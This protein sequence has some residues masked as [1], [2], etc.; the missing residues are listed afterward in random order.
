[1]SGAVTGTVTSGLDV[2]VLGS[3]AVGPAANLFLTQS[4]VQ[5]GNDF[6]SQ[7]LIFS[8][9]NILEM[10]ATI[11]LNFLLILLPSS[12]ALNL[13]LIPSQSNTEAIPANSKVAILTQ[14]FNVANILTINVVIPNPIATHPK[15][16]NIELNALL[17]NGFIV[18]MN[19]FLG[20]VNNFSKNSTIAGLYFVHRSLS[21][22]NILDIVDIMPPS[23]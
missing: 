20:S 4:G 3:E 23:R 17:S 19:N 21:V 18:S 15:F 12:D 13:S 2:V 5:L 11:V 6:N 1:M 9:L 10:P 8:Q 22:E 7:A 14:G 16:S